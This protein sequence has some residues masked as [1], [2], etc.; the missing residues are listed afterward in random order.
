MVD[1][2]ENKELKENVE[3]G[4]CFVELKWRIEEIRGLSFNWYW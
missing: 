1:F 4:V 2:D 3:I